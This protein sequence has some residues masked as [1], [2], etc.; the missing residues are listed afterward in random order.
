MIC[1]R[2]GS[3]TALKASEVVAERAMPV[4]YTHMGIC[5]ARCGICTDF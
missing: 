5:Q 1:R 3:A 2:R 4:L